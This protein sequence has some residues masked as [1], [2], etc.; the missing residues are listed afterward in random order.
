VPPPG[1][2][3]SQLAPRSPAASA[4]S[5]TSWLSAPAVRAPPWPKPRQRACRSVIVQPRTE[6][7]DANEH[8]TP[9][10][11]GCASECLSVVGVGRAAIPGQVWRWWRQE[12]EE[13][14]ENLGVFHK[15]N[16]SNHAHEHTR[17][18][19]HTQTHNHMTCSCVRRHERYTPGVGA[20][21]PRC[22]LCSRMLPTLQ[23][24]TGRSTPP[25]LPMSTCAC[26]QPRSVCYFWFPNLFPDSQQMIVRQRCRV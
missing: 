25:H 15:S 17:T 8:A 11:H 14:E 3:L 23:V 19:W 10:P 12:E 24:R 7:R 13:E 5:L 20:G 21:H 1:D 18:H 4:V 26:V 16:P 9:D 6:N 2:W 22:E